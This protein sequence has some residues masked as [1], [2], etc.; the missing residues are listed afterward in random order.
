MKRVAIIGGGFGGIYTC[1]YLLK[2]LKNV[3]IIL[4]NKINYFI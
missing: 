1:K 3:E 4:I 2:K